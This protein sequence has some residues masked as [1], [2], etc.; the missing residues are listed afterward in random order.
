MKAACTGRI[1]PSANL[2]DAAIENA[3]GRHVEAAGATL[4]KVRGAGA[5]LY[6]ARFSR[7]DR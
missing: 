5:V 2:T 3:W 1:C 7:D 6:A 4:H